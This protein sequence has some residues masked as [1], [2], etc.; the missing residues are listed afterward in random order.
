MKITQN[1]LSIIASLSIAGFVLY[2][3]IYL[4]CINNPGVGLVKKYE[5]FAMTSIMCGLLFLFIF[6]LTLLI[7]LISE[8]KI[9]KAN[10][11]LFCLVLMTYIMTIF[12]EKKIGIDLFF[13]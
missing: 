6:A 7:M 2:S 5:D 8:I 10:K 12:I 9:T 11:I 1:H 3:T 4:F 13:D